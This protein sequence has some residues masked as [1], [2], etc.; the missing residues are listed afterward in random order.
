MSFYKSLEKLWIKIQQK[1]I[2][3]VTGNVD[4]LIPTSSKS[5]KELIDTHSSDSSFI[6]LTKFLSIKSF[7]DF[8]NVNVFSYFSPKQGIVLISK[9][10]PDVITKPKN[11]NQQDE[12]NENFF[13]EHNGVESL[14]EYIEWI[15]TQL[16]DAKNNFDRSNK[17]IFVLNFSDI[18]LNQNTSN[19]VMLKLSELLEAFIEF[20]KT[21]SNKFK[22]DYYKLVIIA[23]NSNVVNSLMT[24]NVEFASINIAKPNKDER[25]EFFKLYGNKFTNLKDTIG[26]YD[27]YDFKNAIS[28]S[29]GL[30]FREMLQL[31]KLNIND[32]LGKEFTFSELYKLATFFKKDSEW[33]KIDV[34]KMA[35]IEKILSERVKGQDK[36]IQKV[37]KTLIRSFIGMNGILH[38]VDNNKPKGIL[39]FAGPTGTGKTEL[40]KSISQFIFDDENRIIRF[41]MSEFNHEHSD[42]RLI[43]APPGYVGYD[44]GG[45]LTNKVKENPFSILLFDEIEK[46]HG[47][48]LDKFLQILEDGRLTSSQGEIVDFGQTFIIFTSNIGS[49]TANPSLNPDELEKHFIK[50]VTEYFRDTLNRPEILNRIG[51]KNIVAFNFIKDINIVKDIVSSKINKI[52]SNIMKEKNIDLQYD[53][54]FINNISEV[55][56]K[57]F[58]KEFG[59]RGIVTELET[60]LIDTL[61]EFIFNNYSQ[62]NKSLMENNVIKVQMIMVDQKVTYKII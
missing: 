39:F 24:N 36:A 9:E 49:R 13:E 54:E 16:S 18:L 35:N 50:N 40:V 32:N 20:K 33:E 3:L 37:K 14:D 15:S 53:E 29:S 42:Q 58:K 43:G 44:A 6:D 62:F 52:K 21:S 17:S 26:D 8:T 22:N 60:I 59:G 31:S 47:K 7:Q 51:D 11:N 10:N 23:R 57:N 27:H 19:L 12:E 55:L 5:Y 28:I 61:V 25:E 41:D 30:S 38:S 56:D 45:E 46:A 4:D 1:N 2:V 48:I 34:N